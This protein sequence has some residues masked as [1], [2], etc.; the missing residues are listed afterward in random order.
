M[1]TMVGGTP[2]SAARS[3]LGAS[4]MNFESIEEAEAPSPSH[5]YDGASELPR[6]V[7][8][9]F[10]IEM[11]E[12]STSEPQQ[13]SI[14]AKESKLDTTAAPSAE[15]EP[16]LPLLY[17]KSQLSQRMFQRKPQLPSFE[18]AASPMEC[19]QG[20]LHD[21]RNKKVRLLYRYFAK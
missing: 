3:P 19:M 20:Y 15:A 17:R 14:L 4:I 2:I 21:T 5:S 10:D 12:S 7:P 8:P 9:T 6:M 11:N 16:T 13:Q 18:L 1:D